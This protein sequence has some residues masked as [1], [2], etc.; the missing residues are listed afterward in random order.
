MVFEGV[1]WP[2]HLE[3]M[4]VGRQ[5]ACTHVLK[6]SP[7]L[8]TSNASSTL[9]LRC[10]WVLS[11]YAWSIPNA[12]IRRN[13][14]Q[15]DAIRRNQTQSRLPESSLRRQSCKQAQSNVIKCGIM[16]TWI[17]LKAAED[18]STGTRVAPSDAYL[19]REAIRRHQSEEGGNQ[20]SSET[21][22][23]AV[24][25][26]TSMG[27]GSLDSLLVPA[28]LGATSC[29]THACNPRHSSMQSESLMHAIRVTQA[30]NPRLLVLL[31]L[32]AFSFATAAPTSPMTL[33]ITFFASMS[34]N[35]SSGALERP[36]A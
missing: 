8:V 22:P 14:T 5:S 23:Q 36:K 26:L 16:I 10:P 15:S 9:H 1:P 12:T 31:P 29:G 17:I 24:A 13:P 30:C 11:V 25:Y 3:C 6:A 4:Q 20:T 18:L 28:K 35:V 21:W 33:S 32:E 34:A 19:M 27:A 2:R 7:G